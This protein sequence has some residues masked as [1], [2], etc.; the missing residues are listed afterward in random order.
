MALIAFARRFLPF[1]SPSGPD[2]KPTELRKSL[3]AIFTQFGKI[4]DINCAKTYTLRGQVRVAFPKSRPPCF[5]EAGDCCP[6]IAIYETDTFLSKKSHRR[7]G[8]GVQNRSRGKRGGDALKE[9]HHRG[10]G[11][12]CDVNQRGTKRAATERNR[13]VVRKRTLTET[14]ECARQ[15]TDRIRTRRKDRRLTSSVDALCI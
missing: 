15:K 4:I 9:G 6:Y 8:H 13:P 1:L 12:D 5:T 11:G 10:V 7:H 3:S 14:E 2:T